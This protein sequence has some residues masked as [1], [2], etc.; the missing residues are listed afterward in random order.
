MET[1]VQYLPKV[2]GEPIK[3]QSVNGEVWVTWAQEA[4]SQLE[5]ARKGHHDAMECAA[6]A[7]IASDSLSTSATSMSADRG[8]NN[9]RMMFVLYQELWY[10]L[11]T[12]AYSNTAAL[13]T[14]DD[15][16]PYLECP[17]GPGL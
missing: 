4:T 12:S 10:A 15:G 17:F 6:A 5:E 8:Q 13:K 11:C 16:L 1:I 14:A 7:V 9:K 3:Y 2:N